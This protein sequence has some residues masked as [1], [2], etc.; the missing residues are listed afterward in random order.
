[1]FTQ[2]QA[3]THY[4]SANWTQAIATDYDAS[5]QALWVNTK[6]PQ[7]ISI[8]ASADIYVRLNGTNNTT[9]PLLFIGAN[10]TFDMPIEVTK[11]YITT[12]ESTSMHVALFDYES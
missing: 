8:R 11:L 3:F 2:D 7:R 9:N 12:T 1:M 4:D 5:A 6:K 10:T